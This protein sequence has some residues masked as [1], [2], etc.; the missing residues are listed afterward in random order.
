M[1]VGETNVAVQTRPYDEEDGRR[2]WLSRA[3]QRVLASFYEERPRRQIAVRLGLCGL[4][5]DEIVDVARDDLRRL[6]A[7]REAY[8]L[9]IEDAKRGD[10]ETP[11]SADL[12]STIRTTAN[13]RGLS[14]EEPV[15]DRSKKQL[16]R[17]IESAAGTLADETGEA[18]WQYVRPHDLR[19]TWATDTYYSLA[20]EG[21]PIAEQ[22]VMGWGGWKMSE[23][24]RKTFREN[25]LGPEPDHV[26]TQAMERAGVL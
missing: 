10:R 16:S 26:A 11:I 22:L 17:W 9:Q 19:R 6:D 4:R 8:K 14:G 18:D 1:R 13:A 23:S 15:V 12:A 5:G 2:V 21:I 3:E 24:G 20:F 7:D 25:Y